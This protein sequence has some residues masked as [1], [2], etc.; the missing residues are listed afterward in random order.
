MSVED[1]Q[2]S[3]ELDLKKTISELN[4]RVSMIESISADRITELEKV[5]IELEDRIRKLEWL[6]N[7]DN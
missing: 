3:V 1:K 2:D 4:D 5:V 7:N 6:K